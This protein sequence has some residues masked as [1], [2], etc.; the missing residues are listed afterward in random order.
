[1]IRQKKK[2]KSNLYL[3]DKQPLTLGGKIALGIS[4]VFLIGWAL[5][6]IWPLLQLIISSFHGEQG[7][8][9]NLNAGFSFSLKHFQH[10]FEN[11]MY[12]KW[13]GNTLFVSIATAVLVILIV[14]FTGYAYSRY[15]FKGKKASL[16]TVMLIQTIPTFV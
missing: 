4:Y 9:L 7:K 12:L 15:R 6:V 10:L 14:S 1:M 13:M 2:K 16:M 5:A 11:T 3:S 8:R